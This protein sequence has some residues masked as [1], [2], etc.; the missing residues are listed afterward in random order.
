MEADATTAAQ[1]RR[2]DDRW[3][4]LPFDMLVLVVDRL[5]W[6]NHPS[7]ALTCRHWRS[8]VS[9][10]Y[11]A[12]ITPLL[13]SSAD[14]GVAN[15][16]YYSPYFHRSF[17]VDGCT[18]N[19]PPEAN[20]CC[21]N[22]RRLTLCLPKLVLQTDLVTGAVDELP[23]MPFYWFNFIVYDDADRRMYCVNTIFVV[24]LARAI[25]DEDGEWGPWDLT[26]FNVEE[27]AQLQAS[28]IS[29][30]V[31][32]GGLLYVLGE[33]GK[34]AVYD[35]CNHDDNF[36]VV[37][38]LKGFGIEHDRVD[39]YLFESDQGELMAVLV[40]YTGTPV[41]V[42]KLNEEIMEW[43]KM[44]SLDGRALFTETYTTMMRKTKLKSMQNKVFLPRLYEWPKTIHV[45]LVIRDGEPTFIPKSHSQYSIEKITSNTSIWSYKVGQQEEARKFWGS[46]KV[47]YSIWVNFSTNLQ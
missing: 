33:D 22:G 37:D 31:L 28:P 9:P 10:F 29:N 13:L 4:S 5:G 11:P 8:A 2:R 32:H 14:V 7:F 20:L 45:D 40:G 30:P 15:A 16:R 1:G 19:V 12:W 3:S 17:E 27:G 23:E 47:D 21:S 41:H 26:E 25:Q 39:S 36:K 6:S 18:L 35:P 43:E 42:L 34:L 46:E 38:K 24:R 44:E